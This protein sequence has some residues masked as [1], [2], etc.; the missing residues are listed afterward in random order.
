MPFTGGAAIQITRDGG[1]TPQESLDGKWLCYTRYRT[2]GVWCT[3]V[4]GGAEQQILNSDIG[5]QLDDGARGH[6]LFRFP[7]EPKRPKAVK[8]YSFETS[9]SPHR[10]GR[11]RLRS[12]VLLDDVW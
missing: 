6:L 7:E 5:R 2:H 11:W 9:G 8:F 12:W 3:P 4:A 10:S 1:F